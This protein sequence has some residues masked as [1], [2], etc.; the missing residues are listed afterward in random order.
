MSDDAG[1]LAQLLPAARA[2][3]AGALGQLLEACRG[4]LLLIAQQELNADLRA[5]VGASDLVQE[6]FLEAQRGFGQFQGDARN[7]LLAWLRRILLNNVA[8]CAR[9]YRA[10]DKR[11]LDRERP[12]PSD[13][14]LGLDGLA[15]H[16]PTPSS[17]AMAEE[18]TRVVEQALERLPE[19]YRRV[20]LLR[21][22]EERSFEEIAQRIGRSANAVRQLWL[23]AIVRLQQELEGPE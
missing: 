22:R 6:T 16:A 13:W 1:E 7:E 11:G 2:G 5:K 17:Q 19:D 10:T 4:Y 21:Y 12:L 23:R 15:R 9:H 20:V 8:N 3:S 18:Q 14:E